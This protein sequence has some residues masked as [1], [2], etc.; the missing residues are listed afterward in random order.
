[1]KRTYSVS[2]RTPAYRQLNRNSISRH[3]EESCTLPA[4]RLHPS[5]R[6]DQVPQGPPEKYPTTGTYLRV[7][8][9][10][11]NSCTNQNAGLKAALT[12]ASVD[13]ACLSPLS[14]IRY[15]FDGVP[16]LRIT[17]EFQDLG[18]VLQNRGICARVSASNGSRA[19]IRTS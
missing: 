17:K 5:C 7:R 10:V 11:P 18:Q 3:R 12:C 19:A 8:L 16:G 13:S 2:S 1:V 15:I 6:Q 9:Y 14:S 4:L